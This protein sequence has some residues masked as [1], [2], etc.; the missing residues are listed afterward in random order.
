VVEAD[1]ASFQGVKSTIGVEVGSLDRD[2]QA[3][4]PLE[5]SQQMRFEVIGV[6]VVACENACGGQD[7]AICIAD[8]QD[9]G[10]FCLLSASIGD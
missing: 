9:I 6:V 8:G 10:C 3:L 4:E 5:R 7:I 2:V 1:L